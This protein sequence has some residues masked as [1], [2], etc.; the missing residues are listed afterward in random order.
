[1]TPEQVSTSFIESL[2]HGEERRTQLDEELKYSALL[3]SAGW[4]ANNLRYGCVKCAPYL[5]R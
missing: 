2:G 4:L 5:T 3:D 1:M